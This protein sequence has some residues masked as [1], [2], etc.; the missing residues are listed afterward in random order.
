MRENIPDIG[1]GEDF[2]DVT[3]KSW[4]IKENL[5]NWASWKFKTFTFQETSLNLKD[6]P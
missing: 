3:L 1:S 6:K 4:S 5:I 2:L